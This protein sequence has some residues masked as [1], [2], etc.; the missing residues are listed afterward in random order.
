VAGERIEAGETLIVLA[1]RHEAPARA[2][3]YVEA[4]AGSRALPIRDDVD[5]VQA[6]DDLAACQRHSCDPTTWLDG[7]LS[8]IAR[9]AIEPHEELTI[10]LGTLIADPSWQR[11]CRCGSPRCRGRIS[12]E[13]WQLR[14]V[15]V[16]YAGHF[17]PLIA[18]RITARPADRPVNGIGPC[19]PAVLAS[20][21]A[22]A[23]RSRP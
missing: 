20:G 8:I 23:T 15:Q 10:D 1:G 21:E 19:E 22:V 16:R 9:R 11:A 6:A 3:A 7:D 5:L 14:D 2:E 13:D 4:H 17:L 18:D 12:G